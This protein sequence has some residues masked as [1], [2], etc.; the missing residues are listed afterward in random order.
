MGHRYLTVFLAA[1]QFEKADA[2]MASGA[3]DGIRDE[4]AVD[5]DGVVGGATKAEE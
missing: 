2:A 1:S 3:A 5:A 4:A